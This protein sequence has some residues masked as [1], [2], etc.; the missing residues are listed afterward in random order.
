MV[1][2]VMR[3]E[4]LL[5]PQPGLDIHPGHHELGGLARREQ[6][7]MVAAFDATE[8]RKIA[9][10]RQMFPDEAFEE[11]GLEMWCYGIPLGPAALNS[12]VSD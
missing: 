1:E 5:H 3:I 4:D 2:R 7:A 11:A 6:P 8:L 10:V 9:A 12:F